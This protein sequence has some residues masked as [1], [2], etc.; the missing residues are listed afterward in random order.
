M[1]RGPIGGGGNND[2]VVKSLQITGFLWGNGA[3]VVKSPKE[4][5]ALVAI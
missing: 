5:H 3:K 2:L 4:E 1:I